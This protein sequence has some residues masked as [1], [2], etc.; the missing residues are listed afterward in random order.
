M[1]AIGART[2]VGLRAE[3]SAAAVR[4]GIRRLT[5]HPSLLDGAGEPL[6]CA[7]DGLL[8]AGQWG[9]ARAVELGKS[10]LNE[11][12][13]KLGQAGVRTARARLLLALPDPRPGFS[14]SEADLIAASLQSAP[15]PAA[16]RLQVE[17]VGGGHAAGLRALELALDHLAQGQDDLCI[18]GGLDSHLD[19]P[20]LAW[21]DDGRRLARKGVRG[22]F[23]PGEGAAM[24]ALMT[25]AA[26]VHFK[27]PSLARIR[28]VA[29]AREPRSLDSDAGLLGEGLTEVV[30]RVVSGLR[31]PDDQVDDIYCD[32]NGERHRTDE[33]GFTVMRHASALRDGTAYQ[34]PSSSWGD[35]G[36]A[37]APLGC[38]LAVQAWRRGYARGP[39]ALVWASSP[40]GL[41]G[42]ALLENDAAA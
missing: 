40:A 32:I 22:G 25:P 13:E 18:V 36:A 3:S 19:L 29:V 34:S 33:W 30:G 5:L 26:R 14:A 24:L 1:V 38:V 35:V 41:R 28:A 15:A 37:S 6:R 8:E 16:L 31:L 4:A 9:V 17:P 10:A 20:T 27:V 21:L 2:P 11:V 23:T 7:R 42:A 39:R 12:L